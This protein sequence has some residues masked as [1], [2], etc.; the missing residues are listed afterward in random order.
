MSSSLKTISTVFAQ[1]YV[2]HR[3]KIL[4]YWETFRHIIYSFK[5]S[6]GCL[7]DIV[8]MTVVV[9]MNNVYMRLY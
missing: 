7:Y 1:K 8:Y 6:Y 9:Y 3:R 4:K 2:L 5:L